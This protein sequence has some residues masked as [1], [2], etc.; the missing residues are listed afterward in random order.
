MVISKI[1]AKC[2]WRFNTVL[3][4]FLVDGFTVY[5]IRHVTFRLPI[6]DVIHPTS[7]KFAMGVKV[8]ATGD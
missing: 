8:K 7:S 5:F 1:N 2:N 4:A 3:E 6:V